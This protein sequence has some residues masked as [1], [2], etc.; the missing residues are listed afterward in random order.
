VSVAILAQAPPLEFPLFYNSF[1]MILRTLAALFSAAICL[2]DAARI[3]FEK[4]ALD[5]TADAEAIAENSS[6][7]VSNIA[8]L[9]IASQPTT[10]SELENQ[11]RALMKSSLARNPELLPLVNSIRDILENQMKPKVFDVKNNQ[12]REV[13][14]L[15]KT[16]GRCSGDL[17]NNV[18]AATEF[19]TRF[20]PL[21]QQ[22]QSCRRS[23]SSSAT[24]AEAC[25]ASQSAA[26]S[27][28]TSKCKIVTDMDSSGKVL[29]SGSCTVSV[30]T[31]SYGDMANRCRDQFGGFATIYF[32]KKKECD[33]ATVV[34]KRKK[35][36]CAT[37]QKI[38]TD[39]LAECDTLQGQMD[40]V[41]CSHV[42]GM[43]EACRSLDSCYD[44]GKANYDAA[45]TAAK[46]E[47]AS[48]KTQLTA[49]LRLQ[50]TLEV[51]TNQGA[52]REATLARCTTQ[53]F[54]SELGKL[55]MIYAPVPA[56]DACLVITDGAGS[57]AY[58]Q[59]QYS[60][61]APNANAKACTASCCQAA[62]P[63]G[64]EV[65]TFK[66]ARSCSLKI[67]EGPTRTGRSASFSLG[68]I[69]FAE[70]IK[71]VPNDTVSS[72]EVRGSPD[73]RATLYQH[74]NFL[75]WAATFP[76]G[77]YDSQDIN[78]RGGVVD[79]ASSAKV[80]YA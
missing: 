56:K 26:D 6:G 16:F 43:A 54:T 51:F 75:G 67:W 9:P 28:A 68:D 39:R 53:D 77:F 34:L 22:H 70:F 35:E 73:C 62:I 80:F 71:E 12:Q 47:E 23:Q 8:E 78:Q 40:S 38:L 65:A 17:K 57:T 66:V 45:V 72:L 21:S 20:G 15:F 58:T 14:E 36:E 7:G 25:T 61:L 10:M 19:Q 79:A 46:T 24:T 76:P 33:D 64:R 44:Q 41:S 63:K 32:Q 49:I 4:A 30:G 3:V 74:A 18:A 11:V 13:N 50:C 48:L 37:A 5:S 60:N 31:E 1:A 69:N 29:L 27:D 52:E 2:A 42:T 59:A 55:S